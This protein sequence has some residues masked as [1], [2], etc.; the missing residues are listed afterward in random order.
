ML[1]TYRACVCI[2]NFVCNVVIPLH[3]SNKEAFYF[4]LIKIKA[5][6]IISFYLRSSSINDIDEKLFFAALPAC[7]S[8]SVVKSSLFLSSRAIVSQQS[9]N[10]MEY[11]M[12]NFVEMGPAI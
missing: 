6:D 12:T 9:N 1:T 10:V 4:I 2:H 3:E 11:N 7:M 8:V 5:C